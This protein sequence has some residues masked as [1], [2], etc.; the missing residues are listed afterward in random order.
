MLTTIL[1]KRKKIKIKREM[2]KFKWAKR[3]KRL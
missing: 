3:P 2:L 1:K